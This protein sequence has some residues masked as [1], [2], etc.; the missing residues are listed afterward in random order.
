MG[1]FGYFVENCL[2][3]YLISQIESITG[4]ENRT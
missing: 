1:G 4:D 2:Y 3:M